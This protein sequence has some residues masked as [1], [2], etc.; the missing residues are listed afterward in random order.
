MVIVENVIEE[1]IGREVT[2]SSKFMGV[3]NNSSMLE[4]RIKKTSNG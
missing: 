2:S 3:V 1:K 4:E